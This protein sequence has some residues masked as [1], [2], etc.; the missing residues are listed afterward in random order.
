MKHPDRPEAATIDEGT[1]FARVDAQ[2][3]GRP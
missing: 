2:N 3:G 1:L